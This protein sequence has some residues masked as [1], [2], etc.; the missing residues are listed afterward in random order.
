MKLTSSNFRKNYYF[1]VAPGIDSHPDAI[2]YIYVGGRNTGKTYSALLYMLEHDM[3]FVFVK[4]TMEDVKIL[5][6]GSGK[7]GSKVK[8]Y[9][10]D[11]SPFVALNRDFNLN[12]RAFSIIPGLGGFYPCDEAG[13]PVGDPI[14]YI[15]ALSAVSKVKGFDLSVADAIIFDEFIPEQW[16]R[17]NRKEGDQVMQLY[18]TVSRDRE[19]RGREP[20]KLIMLANAEM[21]ANPIFDTLEL[22]DTVTFMQLADK[23]E[24]FD[25]RRGIYI[26]RVQTSKEFE[27]KE[28]KSKIYMAMSGTQWAKMALSNEFAYDDF[29]AVK[30]VDLRHFKAMC[31]F[32][33]KHKTYY[34]YNNENI[35][36]VSIR[37]NGK[38]P[39]IDSYDLSRQTEAERFYYNIVLL[40]RS[41]SIDGNVLYETYSLY[42]LLMHFKKHY[43]VGDHA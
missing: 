9:A 8:E 20:L 5:C 41:I 29:T 35:F 22:V 21:V 12:I 3:K 13:A 32:I 39:S 37:S 2:I 14:G 6:S 36:Y 24:Y 17:V 40:L 28:S 25:E 33:H 23:H 30:K 15:V 4:R 18:K 26:N 27:E 1:S 38:M 34:I 7:F 43:T 16:E 31:K 10:E 42:D 19:H 11:L